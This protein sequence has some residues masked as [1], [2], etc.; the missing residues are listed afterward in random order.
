[1]HLEMIPHAPRAMSRQAVPSI[2]L[3][4]LIVCFFGVALFQRDLPRS[5]AGRG[6]TAARDSVGRTSPGRLPALGRAGS[7]QSETGK[8]ASRS[9][10]PAPA[11]RELASLPGE[12]SAT[13]GKNRAALGASDP[14]EGALGRPVR[15]TTRQ[16]GSGPPPGQFQQASVRSSRLR[17]PSVPEP[18]AARRP[19]RMA[20]ARGPRSAFTVVERSETIEDVSS[21]VYGTTLLADSIW[22]ANRDTLPQRDSPLSTGMLLRTPSVR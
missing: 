7:G 22:R 8:Q 1:M 5:H 16:R 6:R 13:D 19:Q 3:S 12:R 15:E 11:R 9:P 17:Q 4:V 20:S 2:V 10:A 14:K 21:R 18:V